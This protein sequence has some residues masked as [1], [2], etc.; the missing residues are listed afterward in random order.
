MKTYVQ[1]D[2]NIKIP[3]AAPGSW[4]PEAEGLL[5]CG[6]TH[7]VS[8]T[9]VISLFAHLKETDRGEESGGNEWVV[10]GA[11]HMNPLRRKL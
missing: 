3:V 6:K 5:G 8:R 2:K 10:R 1:V 7:R 9:D 4:R 11:L